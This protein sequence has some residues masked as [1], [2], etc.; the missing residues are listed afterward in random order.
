MLFFSINVI[1]NEI[2]FWMENV[3]F[4]YKCY[5]GWR[6]L[7]SKMNVKYK[8]YSGWRMLFFSINVI[9]NEKYYSG[10]RMLF[11]SINVILQYKCYYQ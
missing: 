8:C 7:L 1:I 5:S 11:S 6:M 10:W 9:I 2:L 3:V 4:Q